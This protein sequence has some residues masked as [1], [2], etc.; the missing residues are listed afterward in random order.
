[1]PIYETFSKRQKRRRRLSKTDVFQYTDLPMAFRVQVIHIWN[2]TIGGKEE[3]WKFMHDTLAREMGVFNLGESYQNPSAQCQYFLLNTDTDSALD[4]IELSFRIIDQG[5]R[6]LD[7]YDKQRHGIKQEPDDA[8]QELNQR[9][10]EHSIGFQF[11]GGELVRIDSQYIHEEAVK[12]AILLL[13]E[14]GF[15][16]AS[17][18]FLRAH[19]HY[20]KG[21]N[22]EAI[23]EAL[24][25][26][27]SAMKAICDVREWTYPENATAVP[28]V[29]ILLEKG[30]IPKDL[31]SHFSALRTA[32]ESGLPTV[33]N[34]TSRHGQ[35]KEPKEIPSYFAAYALHLAASNI[36]FLVEAHKSTK[37]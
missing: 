21:R 37:K 19:E 32:M 34:R 6:K 28:L 18:E 5:I 1:M 2:D 17:D 7:S 20:R 10:L 29:K 11:A 13:Q 25:A 30:L 15:R 8:I 16:G 33:S 9:F 36:V 4:I 24:K 26:F 12:P 3:A 35:G 22:K 23:A 31:E 14:A 27:E